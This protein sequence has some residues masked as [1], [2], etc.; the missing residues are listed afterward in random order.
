MTVVVGKNGKI[1]KVEYGTSPV[2]REEVKKK[3][4][5]LRK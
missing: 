4:E 2:Q 3:I 5:E 1:A